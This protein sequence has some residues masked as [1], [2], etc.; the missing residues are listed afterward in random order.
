M[1]TY[2]PLFYVRTCN[3]GCCNASSSVNRDS[4]F[5]V[6]SLRI[7]S[8]AKNQEKCRTEVRLRSE[9]PYTVLHVKMASLTVTKTNSC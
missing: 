1:V 5:T 7:K 3:H 8:L 4:G 2:K 9:V 6:R